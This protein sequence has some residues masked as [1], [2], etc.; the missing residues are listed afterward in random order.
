MK[1]GFGEKMEGSMRLS[2]TSLFV[3][4]M[5]LVPCRRH[6]GAFS[7]LRCCRDVSVNG[8][9]ACRD[10]NRPSGVRISVPLV[11]GR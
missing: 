2:G 5:A 9:C 4:A 11:L 10:L 1:L 3:A 6:S 8:R 7:D